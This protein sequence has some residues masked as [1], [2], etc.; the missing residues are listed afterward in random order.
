MS[1]LKDQIE[2]AIRDFDWDDYG[3]DVVDPHSEYAEWVPA[4]AEKIARRALQ[5]GRKPHPNT[6]AAVATSLARRAD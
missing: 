1:M 5:V 3:L 4:L 6:L 2:Q